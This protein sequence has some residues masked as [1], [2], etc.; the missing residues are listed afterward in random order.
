[1]LSRATLI[2][3]TAHAPTRTA[4]DSVTHGPIVEAMSTV[5]LPGDVAAGL[6]AAAKERCVSVD[7]LAAERSRAGSGQAP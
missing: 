2:E 6:A 7:E 3:G 1:M 4:R 5:E